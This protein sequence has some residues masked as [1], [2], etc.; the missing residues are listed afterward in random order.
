MYWKARR[1]ASSFSNTNLI[2]PKA[3]RRSAYGSF[4]PV[5]FSS[6]AQKPTSVSILSASA[7]AT[8]TGSVG[9][10]S[11][12]TERLVMLFDGRGDARM[13]ALQRGVIASHQSLQLGKFADHLGD[14][15]RL[16]QT[17]RT[18]RQF[19]IG[20]NICCK[21]L[22]PTPRCAP[23]AHIA[24]RASRETRWI[25]AFP[26]GL[27]AAPSGPSPRRTWRRTGARAPPARCRPRWSRRR[28]W[29]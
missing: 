17:G 27:R 19:G 5:G 13:L 10:R 16:R 18:L 6:M 2:T 1:L 12:G 20:A 8:E 4:D 21:L 15:I 9:T 29:R 22:A 23:R 3:A 11:D 26:A 25:S 7:T 28:R 14:K 24:C